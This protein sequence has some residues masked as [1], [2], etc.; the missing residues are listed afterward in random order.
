MRIRFFLITVAACMTI[1]LTSC[2]RKTLR[3]IINR[4]GSEK[5]EKPEIYHEYE[6]YSPGLKRS[7]V[8][9]D[10]NRYHYYIATEPTIDIDYEPEI[11]FRQDY[12]DYVE[13]DVQFDE[14]KY[15][16]EHPIQIDGQPEIPESTPEPSQ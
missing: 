11:V 2:D 4:F 5:K 1:M 7:Q 10:F 8:E 14:E 13:P 15:W 12:E 6:G 16:R 9:E 3:N